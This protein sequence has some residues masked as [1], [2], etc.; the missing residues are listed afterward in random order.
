MLFLRAQQRYGHFFIC[1]KRPLFPLFALCFCPVN[2]SSFAPLGHTA[3]KAC[4]DLARRGRSALFLVYP[5]PR[6]RGSAPRVDIAHR[7]LLSTQMKPPPQGLRAPKVDTAYKEW[8]TQHVQGLA[9]RATSV[10]NRPPTLGRRSAVRSTYFAH[11]DLEQQQ[12]SLLAGTLPGAGSQ[13]GR[14]RRNARR[15]ARLPRRC[16]SW[17]GVRT[18]LWGGTR[19]RPARDRIV[20]GGVHAYFR[21]G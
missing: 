20:P 17:T 9:M 5:R 3:R 10:P 14:G 4:L 8:E 15:D 16:L 13:H 2:H 6:A 11:R 21:Y 7:E 18:I 12:T 19:L 1:L